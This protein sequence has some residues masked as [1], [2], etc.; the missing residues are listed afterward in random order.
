M[1]PPTIAPGTPSST[2]PGTPSSASA[3]AAGGSREAGGTS[4]S[5]LTSARATGATGVVGRVETSRGWGA[6]AV[7]AVSRG[8]EGGGGGGGAIACTKKTFA[9][10]AG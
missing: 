10:V 6:R 4:P 2:P 7:A 5:G 3:G 8:A 9:P 1:T